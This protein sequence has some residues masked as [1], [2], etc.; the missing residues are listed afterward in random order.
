MDRLVR[1]RPLGVY[2][3]ADRGVQAARDGLGPGALVVFGPVQLTSIMRGLRT[4]STGWSASS[5]MVLPSFDVVSPC[6][7]NVTQNRCSR[8]CHTAAARWSPSIC[9]VTGTHGVHTP[10]W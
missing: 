5:W 1:G 3:L 9:T 8:S 2:R 10:Y 7:R 4:S 6:S